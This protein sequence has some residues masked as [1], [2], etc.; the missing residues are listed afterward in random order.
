MIHF[1]EAI[2]DKNV[3]LFYFGLIMLAGAIVTAILTQ[4]SNLQ[5]MGV[6]A[7][8]KPMKFYLSGFILAWTIGYF[9]QYLDNQKQVTIYNWVYIITIG[10][11]LLAITWQAALGKQSHFNKDTTFDTAV[12]YL[13]GLMITIVTLWTAYIGVLFFIQKEFTASPVLIWSV[14]LGLIMTA[15]FAFEGGIMAAMLRHS[16]GGS[17]GDAGIPVVNWSKQHGDLRVAHFFGIHALQIIP[18]LSVYLAKSVQQVFVIAILFF[19]FVTY[20]LVQAFLGKPFL[21]L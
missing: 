21:S 8:L 3:M 13:M 6:S 10:Y 1:I 16:V 20:T 4:T 12:F 7:F 15:V 19:A 11:E 9:M 5:V 2:R 17:D 18:L 14:R